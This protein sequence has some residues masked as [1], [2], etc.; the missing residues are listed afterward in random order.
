MARKLDLGLIEGKCFQLLNCFRSWCLLIRC[1]KI[2]RNACT[3]KSAKR[4]IQFGQSSLSRK[5]GIIQIKQ[6]QMT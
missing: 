4:M 5:Q 6:K 3:L 1:V 2:L